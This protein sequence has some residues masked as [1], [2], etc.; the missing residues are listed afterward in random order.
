MKDS[1]KIVMV[2]DNFDSFSA[3]TKACQDSKGVTIVE[4]G[5][6][7]EQ[8]PAKSLPKK[9]RRILKAVNGPDTMQGKFMAFLK[10]AANKNKTFSMIEIQD[11]LTRNSFMPTSWGYLVGKLLRQQLIFKDSEDGH[12]VY[13]L[14][15]LGGK[16][17]R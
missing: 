2:A 14:L 8:L 16:S 13:G 9:R 17:V 5:L 7:A 11:W 12:A 4:A 15:V 10:L 3:V 1:W 6:I